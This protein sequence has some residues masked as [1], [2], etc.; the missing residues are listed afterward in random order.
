MAFPF[1]LLFCR[2]ADTLMAFKRFGFCSR[3]IRRKLDVPGD[4]PCS[5]EPHLTRCLTVVDLIAL[6]VGSTLGA[7]VY[8]LAGA[9]ARDYTG[10][11]IVLSFLIAAVTSILA[12]VCYAEFGAR[13]PGA[14]SAYLY[15]YLTVGEFLA[16]VTGW[17]LILS[18][19]IG[20]SSVARAWSANFDN[21]IGGAIRDFSHRALPIDVPGLSKHPDF[22][23]ALMILILTAVLCV[24]V[25]ESAIVSKVFTAVNVLV[26]SCVVISSFIKG[27]LKNWHLG[28]DDI[29][30]IS[31]EH[32]QTTDAGVGGFLP[33]GVHGVLQ[34]AATCFYAFVGFDCIA[35]TG[36]EV[37][38]PQRA[39]P[40]SIIISL[41]I[42]FAA[43]FSVS[44]ALTLLMPYFL[45]DDESPLPAAFQ[46]VGWDPVRYLIAIG[47]L[48]ALTSSLLGSI[49]PLPRIVYAMADDGLLFRWL[50]TISPRFHT[51]LFA[52]VISGIIGAIMAFLF[53]LIALVDLMSIGTL[54]SYSLVAL[55][56]LILRY[57]PEIIHQAGTKEPL[58][59]LPDPGLSVGLLI[60]PSP[61]PTRSSSMIV[62]ILLSF[63]CLDVVILCCFLTHG[64]SKIFS[65]SPAVFTAF[66]FFLVL[67]IIA[68]ILIWFQPQSR[69]TLSFK[70][71]FVPLFPVLSILVN[72]YL[73]VILSWET[74]IRFSVW[75][76]IGFII[77]FFYGIS[78]SSEGR[79]TISNVPPCERDGELH[80]LDQFKRI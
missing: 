65:L 31:K 53:D 47:A 24:G 60:H 40:M 3:L 62:N 72:T 71:P 79:S 51:P 43:Y 25:R 41:L 2:E 61:Y 26:L 52:T 29:Y 44:A 6:G 54:L 22:F 58:S 9:V 10:P 20:A 28:E 36:E 33:F 21:M 1:D 76:L 77:Y 35:T 18:Y 78:H 70:V 69:E 50:A 27:D 75:M 46:Y 14:G 49:F 39:I 59:D 8:V 16:F 63:I 56:V 15:S 37:K 67:F 38:N 55:A 4:A 73:M 32:N 19:V 23:A 30:N 45:L 57:R 13:A 7:G 64:S 12:G 74:W 80:S 34:G 11:A 42:C 68:I 5:D 48:C 66:I 17:T